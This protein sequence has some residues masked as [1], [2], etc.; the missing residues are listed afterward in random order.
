MALDFPWIYPVRVV[1]VIFA[2]IILG[3]TAYSQSPSYRKHG[4]LKGH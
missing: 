4:K 1:Q 2:I 3:L